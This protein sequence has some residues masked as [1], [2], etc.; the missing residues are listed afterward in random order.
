MSAPVL[1]V[2]DYGPAEGGEVAHQQGRR[3]PSS[4]GIEVSAD[5]DGDDRHPGLQPAEPG[6]PFGQPEGL[7]GENLTLGDRGYG[8]YG[9]EQSQ[10]GRPPGPAKLSS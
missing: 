6:L 10:V 8:A 9:D 2:D 5:E 3:G 1:E 7:V 4:G